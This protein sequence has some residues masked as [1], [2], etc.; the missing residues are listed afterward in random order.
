MSILKPDA[1]NPDFSFSEKAFEKLYQKSPLPWISKSS[2]DASLASNQSQ[3]SFYMP[4]V[5]TKPSQKAQIFSRLKQNKTPTLNYSINSVNSNL[6]NSNNSNIGHTEPS[7]VSDRHKTPSDDDSL[8]TTI[9]NSY[10]CSAQGIHKATLDHT[11]TEREKNISSL[12]EADTVQIDVSSTQPGCQPIDNNENTSD[13]ITTQPGCLPTDNNENTSDIITFKQPR[14]VEKSGAIIS[15]D[16]CMEEDGEP[17]EDQLTTTNTPSTCSD[18]QSVVEESHGKQD[19]ADN[20]QGI[21]RK[22]TPE[23]D[24]NTR[25]RAKQSVTDSAIPEKKSTP[26]HLWIIKPLENVQGICVEGKRS[27]DDDEFW[28][29]GL[30][31]R[32]LGRNLVETQSGS[33][34]QLIHSIQKEDALLAGIPKTVVAAFRQGFPTK[35]KELVHKMFL[36]QKKEKEGLH[37]CLESESSRQESSGED[38]SAVQPPVTDQSQ[39]MSSK[40][41]EYF[42]INWTILPLPNCAGICVEG[43]KSGSKNDDEFWHSTAIKTRITNKRLLSVSGSIYNLVGSMNRGIAL[44][45]GFPVAVVDVFTRGFPK[46]WEDILKEYHDMQ[47]SKRSQQGRLLTP[48]R[49]GQSL[50]SK[51]VSTPTGQLVHLDSLRKTR[52]GRL[53]KPVLAWWAG[54]NVVEDRETGSLGVSYRSTLAKSFLEEFTEDIKNSKPSRSGQKKLAKSYISSSDHRDSSSSDKPKQSKSFSIPRKSSVVV[55]KK[56]EKSSRASVDIVKSKQEN[57]HSRSRSRTKSSLDEVSSEQAKSRSQSRSQSSLDEVRREPAKSRSRTQFSLDEVYREPAKSRSRTKS[58]LDEVSREP[59]KFRSRSRSQSSLDEVRREPAKSQSRTQSSLDEVH[60]EPAISRSR[61]RTKSSLDEV[62]REP[63][64]SRSRS[65]SQSNVPVMKKEQDK[66][67]SQSRFRLRILLE[68]KTQEN[69]QEELVKNVGIE[70]DQ[71]CKN[72]ELPGSPLSGSYKNREN[73]RQGSRRSQKKTETPCSTSTDCDTDLDVEQQ[74][75]GVVKKHSERRKTGKSEPRSTC[76]REL[77]PVITPLNEAQIGRRTTRKSSEQE[78]KLCTP[79][80][81]QKSNIKTNNEKRISAC[82]SKESKTKSKSNRRVDDVHSPYTLSDE[83]GPPVVHTVV[84]EIVQPQ[85]KKNK[86]KLVTEQVSQKPWSKTELSLLHKAVQSVKGDRPDFWDCVAEK[87]KRRTIEECK[88][89]Y[90]KE[91]PHKP[92]KMNAATKKKL[93][94]VPVMLTGKVGTMK[95]KQQLRDFIEQQNAGYKDDLFSSTPFRTQSDRILQ[96]TFDDDEG[97]SIFDELAKKNPI[98]LSKF[99]TPNSRFY[100][101]PVSEKK[102]PASSLVSPWTTVNRKEVDQYVKKIQMKRRKIVK[103]KKT[104]EKVP[105]AK[106]KSL[107]PEEAP[108]KSLFGSSPFAKFDL[109]RLFASDES[110]DQIVDE[111]EEQDYYWSDQMEED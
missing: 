100:I 14:E 74:V 51:E 38:N 75:L 28:H 39:Q 110:I 46:Y 15:E 42:L 23:K 61:S 32:R 96:G 41:K 33:R 89:T 6:L 86:V 84:K 99:H 52:S 56:S 88:D 69:V 68:K 70:A 25:S 22:P 35:W 78:N 34:Y 7:I 77:R 63:V 87:L 60:R 76:Y 73:I 37:S 11:G 13:I 101:A 79:A 92:P 105:E 62:R 18:L 66:P 90:F 94:K 59:A 106:P 54:Q 81:S 55:N 4:R 40:N 36:M 91:I 97:D 58:S 65:R 95:R 109:N 16:V 8:S 30:I 12:L 98:P 10:I 20:S 29:S 67:P 19:N 104:K 82:S 44:E 27:P 85:M 21:L 71:N 2:L 3:S 64:K 103:N 26:L 47:A 17:E 50:H 49:Q 83:E 1:L 48:Q 43:K 31:T 9:G 72:F 57:S 111:E 5:V 93:D 80:E 45:A 102:T 53:V 108:V 24:I 107:A